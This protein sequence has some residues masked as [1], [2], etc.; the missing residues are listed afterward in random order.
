MFPSVRVPLNRSNWIASLITTFRCK[1]YSV[2]VQ[3]KPFKLHRLDEGPATTVECTR[4]QALK[5]YREMTTVR[6]LEAAANSLYKERYVRG[7]CHLYTGQE[8]VCVG[9]ENA[10]R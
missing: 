1:S 9:I 4:L 8:A 2:T 7:F 3:V 5:Y 10:I 6:R